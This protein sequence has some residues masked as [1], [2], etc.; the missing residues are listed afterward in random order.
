MIKLRLQ[1]FPLPGHQFRRVLLPIGGEFAERGAAGNERRVNTDFM[2]VVV[3]AFFQ[4]TVAAHFGVG[5]AVKFVPQ[6][7][8]VT[9]NWKREGAF[10]GLA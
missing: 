6:D 3:S 5:R 7:F 10:N 9:V 8:G 4:I 2:R 1:Q